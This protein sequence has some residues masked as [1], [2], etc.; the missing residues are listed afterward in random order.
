MVTEYEGEDSASLL[1]HWLERQP[2]GVLVFRDAQQQPAGFVMMVA[3][4]QA[5]TEEL[6]A[7]PAASSAWLY[8]QNHAPLRT[9]EGATLSYGIG[10]SAET[11]TVD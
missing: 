11:S 3:L 7:D 8:L 4:H 1:A 10:K 5:S 9:G 2:Q 6:K